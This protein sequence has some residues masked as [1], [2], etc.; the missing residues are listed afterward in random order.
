[1][2]NSC[3]INDY[4]T[5]SQI[6]HA[7]SDTATGAYTLASIAPDPAQPARRG[8]DPGAPAPP[9][10]VL[11]APFAHAPHTWRDPTTGALVVVFEGR[12]RL[13][14]SAQKRC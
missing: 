5:N 12:V 11:V 9:E 1:M 13:P 4:I 8:V 3:G 2:T 7:Q 14:D 10:A 6:V